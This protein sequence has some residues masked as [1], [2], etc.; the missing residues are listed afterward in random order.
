[1]RRTIHG[2]PSTDEWPS[3]SPTSGT[4]PSRTPRHSSWPWLFSRIQITSP[5]MPSPMGAEPPAS[6]TRCGSKLG[7]SRRVISRSP[8][9]SSS[10][11]G[12]PQDQKPH[13]IPAIRSVE[14][15]RNVNGRYGRCHS[16]VSSS[17]SSS[18]ATARSS[19]ERNGKAA[20][21]PARNAPFTYGSSTV[22]AAI[23]PYSRWISSC[24]ATSPRTRTCSF[25]H[26]QPRTKAS[27]SGRA[28]A[29]SL[30]ESARPV[31]SGSRMSG[32][33]LPTARSALTR[34]AARWRAPT[35]HRSRRARRRRP[36][37]PSR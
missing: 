23:R 25:G 2:R 30:S 21:I 3:S 15:S 32:N 22:T 1:M 37:P 14:S 13:Q 20:P 17:R 12:L 18:R 16:S 29:I 7:C 24:I 11:V 31:V 27:T 35:P 36:R 5:S 9:R 8:S 19:S 33:W 26:H 28:S 4:G 10:G 6:Q 34:A